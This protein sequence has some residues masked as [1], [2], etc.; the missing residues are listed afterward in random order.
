M[1]GSNPVGRV[2]VW[3]DGPLQVIGMVP[4]TVYCDRPS[5]SLDLL[6]SPALSEL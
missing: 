6:L 3:Q 1:A 4:D 2:M 5:A